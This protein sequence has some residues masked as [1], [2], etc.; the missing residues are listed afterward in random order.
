[1]TPLRPTPHGPEHLRF[2]A[3]LKRVYF[4]FA[5]AWFVAGRQGSTGPCRSQCRTAV[6]T[7]PF[8][9]VLATSL[10]P[11]HTPRAPIALCT[12][13]RPSSRPAADTCSM[14]QDES[15]RTQTH[16]KYSSPMANMCLREC[17]CA[18]TSTHMSMNTHGGLVRGRQVFERRLG[19]VCGSRTS[20]CPP[21]RPPARMRTR[22]RTHAQVML[23]G[24]DFI[25]FQV[26]RVHAGMLA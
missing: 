16:S 22:T 17:L 10:R 25:A 14:C 5:E 3:S 11:W 12:S 20:A 19:V 15:W 24:A 1:M 9:F 23:S 21:A 18:C 6:L 4:F 26:G 2:C 8:R 7:I 13:A